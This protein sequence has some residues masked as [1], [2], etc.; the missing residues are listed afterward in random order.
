MTRWLSLSRRLAQRSR[1]D[2]QGSVMIIVALWIG[3]ILGFAALGVDVAYLYS[4]R[5]KLQATADTA[6]LAAAAEFPDV[7]AARAAALEYA[8]KN[9]PA[10]AHGNVLADADIVIGNWDSDTRTFDPAGSPQNAVQVTVRRAQAN[11]NPV[12]LLFAQV[13]G[14]TDFDLA[15]AAT[16]AIGDDSVSCIHALN[17]TA[18]R[19]LWLTGNGSVVTED[20]SVQ[21]DSSHGSR[22][23]SVGN[24][25]T[26]QANGSAEICVTGGWD[27]DGTANP[28]PSSCDALGDPMPGFSAPSNPDCT[29]NNVS[30]SD[31]TQTLYPGYYCGGISISGNSDVTFEGGVYVLD[32]PFNASGNAVLN[33]D[34]VG[35]YFTDDPG[36]DLSITGNAN[37]HFTASD[38]DWMA[39]LVFYGDRGASGNPQFKLA[40]NGT[41]YLEGTA[42]FPAGSLEVSG[43]GA[44]QVPPYTNLI[45]DTIKFSGNGS[46]TYDSDYESSSVPLPAGLGSG[47][48]RLVR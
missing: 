27:V 14:F 23:L 44:A 19:A 26:L 31:E 10:E 9:M 47:G 2:E 34:G 35:F 36:A 25:A 21:V 45:A 17:P 42:Y 13:L 24:N 18:Q 8:G 43:N 5:T 12:S 39:G 33:G 20:C 30:V 37:V 22:A 11:G 32:G 41:I 29:Y 46:L 48:S 6:G 7:D 16:A 38:S 15:T 1:E 3:A 4:I 40:G 28:S